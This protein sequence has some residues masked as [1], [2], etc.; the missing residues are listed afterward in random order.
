MKPTC[1]M[2]N[3]YFN[4]SLQSQNKVK[5]RFF[6]NVAIGQSAVIFQLLSGKDQ[7]LLVRRNTFPIL[8]LGLHILDSVTCLHFQRYG[9]SGQGLDEN[10]HVTSQNEPPQKKSRILLNVVV[11]NGTAIFQLLTGKD[12][13]LLIREGCLLYLSNFL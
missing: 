8:N 12:K 11:R 1:Q 9:L 2:W 13:T 10:L 7:S 4:S 6:L 3:Y 5:C